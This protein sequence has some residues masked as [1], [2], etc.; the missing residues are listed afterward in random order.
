MDEQVD[1]TRDRVWAVEVDASYTAYVIAPTGVEAKQIAKD[2]ADHVDPSY[3]AHEVTEPLAP[4][5]PDAES[6]LYGPSRCED[7]ELTV[8]EAVELIASRKPAFDTET[9]LMPFADSPPPLH[10][11][12]I[13]DYLATARAGNDTTTGE[14]ITDDA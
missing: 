2:E 4:H 6:T 7:R 9:V 5:H 11:A 8:N 14:E 10:P 3:Y 12:R 13:E 1:P